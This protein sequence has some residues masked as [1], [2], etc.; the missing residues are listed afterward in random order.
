MKWTSQPRVA[1]CRA[2]T[3]LDTPEPGLFQDRAGKRSVGHLAKVA[4]LA[5]QQHYR[6][7]AHVKGLPWLREAVS[8]IVIIQNSL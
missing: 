6:E 2:H 8:F 5:A 1:E 7:S 4:D 3:V